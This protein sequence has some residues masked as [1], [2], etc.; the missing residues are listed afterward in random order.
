MVVAVLYFENDGCDETAS[1]IL[2]SGHFMLFLINDGFWR[3]EWAGYLA[4][5]S[6]WSFR[7][8]IQHGIGVWVLLPPLDTQEA[9]E[10]CLFSEVYICVYM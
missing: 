3:G 2:H 5:A 7:C 4:F 9:W 8:C 6:A 1:S 10:D